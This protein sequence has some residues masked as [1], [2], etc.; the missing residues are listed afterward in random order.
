MTRRRNDCGPSNPLEL[1]REEALTLLKKLVIAWD[2]DD[3]LEF[4]EAVK[5]ARKAIGFKLRRKADD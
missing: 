4:D 1:S 3:L 5:E 2:T